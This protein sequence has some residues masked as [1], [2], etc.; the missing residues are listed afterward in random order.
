MVSSLVV[1]GS[2]VGFCSAGGWVGGVG[3]A[4]GGRW[5]RRSPAAPGPGVFGLGVPV[6]VVGG[7]S[8]RLGVVAGGVPCA[9]PAGR[10]GSWFCGR[11]VVA[12]PGFGSVVVPAARVR[13]FASSPAAVSSLRRRSVRWLFLVA[14]F[15]AVVGPS[16]VAGGWG[17]GPL[18]A[19]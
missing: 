19:G 6:W 5:V 11:L 16:L 2:V 1:G 15:R 10:S 18:L 17:S 9:A 4:A 7:S 14:A 3:R 8:A 12:V 13:V